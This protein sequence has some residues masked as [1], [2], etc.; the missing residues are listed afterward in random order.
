MKLRGA[1]SGFGQVAEQGHLPGWRQTSGIEIVAVHEPLAARR[2]AALRAFDGRIRVYEDLE[3]MLDGERLDFLDIA[4]PPRYHA[5]AIRLA[6]EAGAHV[7]V[8][9]PL[10]LPNHNLPA[11]IA[12]ASTQRRLLYCVH[13]WKYAPAYRRARQLIDEGRLGRV[14]YCAMYRLRTTHAGGAAWRI[15]PAVGG[16]GILVDHGWHVFYLMQWLTDDTPVVVAARLSLMESGTDEL[17][18]VIIDFRNGAHGYAHMSWVAPVRETSAIVYGDRGWL[19]IGE[20]RLRLIERDGAERQI[21][22]SDAPDDSYHAAWFS[23]LAAEFKLALAQGADGELAR[24]NRREAESAMAVLKAAQASHA[25][26]GL[27]QHL[28]H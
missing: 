27:P 16:G 14:A 26:R 1:I 21:E 10:C 22:V 8:E 4:S 20:R 12:A 23:S 25:A 13:N 28:T 6:L 3:L 11:L 9:K 5:Q 2:Q 15:D 7:L 17:A 18:D 24:H 19:A